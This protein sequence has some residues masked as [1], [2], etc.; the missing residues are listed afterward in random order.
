[1]CFNIFPD[2]IAL[3]DQLQA[4]EGNSLLIA[5]LQGIQLSFLK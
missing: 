5:G 4:R 2:S 1:M 3:P